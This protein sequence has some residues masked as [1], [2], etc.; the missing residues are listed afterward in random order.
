MSPDIFLKNCGVWPQP[1]NPIFRKMLEHI[2]YLKI[3]WSKW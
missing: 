1:E 3:C 2:R